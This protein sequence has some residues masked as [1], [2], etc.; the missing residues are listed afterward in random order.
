M[1]CV[2]GAEVRLSPAMKNEQVQGERRRTL[3]EERSSSACRLVGRVNR[4]ERFYRWTT[5][6]KRDC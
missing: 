2:G 5:M 1:T 4:R 3:R 6:T